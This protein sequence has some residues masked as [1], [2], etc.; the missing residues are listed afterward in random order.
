MIPPTKK[1]SH[2]EE[3]ARKI[4]LLERQAEIE[5]LRRF[6]EVIDW[7]TSIPLE[8]MFRKGRGRKQ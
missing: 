5:W 2:E 6:V 7:D 1:S 8:S 4:M 3:T